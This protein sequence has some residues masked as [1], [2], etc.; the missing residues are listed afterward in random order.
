MENF[1]AVDIKDIPYL[2]IAL[3]ISF[4]CHEFAHAY[5]A[6]LLGDPTPEKQGRLTL[7]PH[8]HLDPLGFI[9]VFLLGF[10]WAKPVQINPNN[11]SKPT[12]DDII[13]S[14]AG[15]MANLAIVILSFI[16][17]Y[18]AIALGVGHFMSDST[19][20]II[21]NFF[22]NIVWLNSSLFVFNLLPIPPLD[23]FH[24]AKGLF[25]NEEY[26]RKVESSENVISILMTIFI[27]SGMGDFILDP[28]FNF[29]IPGIFNVF[30]K[31]LAG[32]L[33][34]T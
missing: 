17:W 21:Y 18:G 3:L 31:T 9:A 1:L 20:N 6:Y 23:G 24:I 4:T 12:R 26:R 28:I 34:L 27:F 11:F 8:K 15:P 30:D 5:A 16:I 33:G 32:L 7:V 19:Y 22:D 13:V 29:F 25:L 14:L 10:G 2:V